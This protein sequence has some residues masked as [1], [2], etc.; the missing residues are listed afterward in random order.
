VGDRRDD[1]VPPGEAV[2]SHAKTL[3]TASAGEL[4]IGP[5]GERYK[6]LRLLGR[7]GMGAVYLARDRVLGKQ[8]A[9]KLV[10]GAGPA[11]RDE[12][13]HAHA[14]T[15]R[16]VCRTYD[17]EL[18]QRR[19]LVKMEYVDGVTLEHHVADAGGALAVAEVI[20]IAR[21]IAD[22]L[23]AAHAQGVVHRD[24]KPSNVMVERGG[25]VVLM[26]FG[27]ANIAVDAR[28]T[29]AGIAGTPDFMAPEQARGGD[30]DTR[31]DLYS[32]GCVVYFLL[33]GTVVFPA[34]KIMDTLFRHANDAPPDVRAARPDTPAWLA[35][36]VARMLEKDPA[37]RPASAADVGRVLAAA[38]K[39]PRK[40]IWVAAAALAAVAAVAVALLPARRAPGW[41]ARIV[42]LPA[43]DENADTPDISP[44]GSLM[45]Y[46]SDREQ[47]DHFRIY[48]EPL[49]GGAA[50]AVTP[51]EM[52]ALSPRFTTDGAYIL[53]IDLGAD[54]ARR[55]SL[56]GGTVEAVNGNTSSA[57]PCGDAL[58]LERLTPHALVLR[59]KDGQERDVLRF[60]SEQVLYPRCDSAGARIVVALADATGPTPHPATD[61][62]LVTLDGQRRRLTEDAAD[63]Y[64]GSFRPDGRGLVFSSRRSGHQEL[65]ELPLAGGEPTQLTFGGGPFFAPIV[66]PDGRQILFDV[67]ETAQ[68]LFATSADGGRR[69]LTSKIEDVTALSISPDGATLAATVAHDGREAIE[70][71]PTAGGDARVLADGRSPEF[72]GDGDEIAFVDSSDPTW[73]RA[74]PRTGG[75]PRSV[76]R[77]PGRVSFLAAGPEGQLHLGVPK[78]GAFRVPVQGGDPVL[79]M[80]PPCVGLIPAPTGGWRLASTEEDRRV[81]GPA[82]AL[83][84][85]RARSI[86]PGYVA[87]DRDG[88]SFVI[89]ESST[90][91]RYSVETDEAVTILSAVAGAVAP[92]PDQKTLY[93]TLPVAHVHR[94]LITNYGDRPRP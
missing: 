69:R 77:A 44:D 29:A 38:G 87:W 68:Q 5:L 59:A 88:R 39:R 23:A 50:R 83:D 67:D 49:A 66:S 41:Q 71:I 55:V 8:V 84:D 65:W 46:P 58:L 62:W 45:A 1:D 16:N 27:I 7:G 91:V 26:D 40:G 75:A 73:V 20:A 47:R 70:V 54:R 35:E 24:L 2:D 13:R 86:G 53:F 48:V 9:L 3:A 94:A 21:Q 57:V 11:L 63:N 90:V 92:S 6:V 93:V 28:S 81:L 78:H 17:L 12:V 33:V 89:V 15:H 79:E 51:P 30:V 80:P 64:P 43:Y 60:K 19:W 56:A 72:I 32:L 74:V 34:A 52:Q 4:P 10:G 37:R 42:D 76:T 14:V 36:L 25:R 18:I 31:A 22:G 85:P 61:L 82:M